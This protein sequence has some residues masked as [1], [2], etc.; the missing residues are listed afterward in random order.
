MPFEVDYSH[1]PDGYYPRIADTDTL[2][3]YITDGGIS[4]LINLSLFN[5]QTKL[6]EYGANKNPHSHSSYHFQD[7]NDVQRFIDEIIIPYLTMM[8]MCED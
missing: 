1:V 8:M 2:H 7:P 3:W 6:E 5:Y 4:T